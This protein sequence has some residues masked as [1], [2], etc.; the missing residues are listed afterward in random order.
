MLQYPRTKRVDVVDEYHGVSVSDPYRWL[1]DTESPETSAWIGAQNALTFEHLEGIAGR[2]EILSRLTELWGYTRYGTPTHPV[3]VLAG[4]RRFYLRSDGLQDQPVLWVEPEGGQARVLLDPNCLSEDGAVALTGFDVTH[5]GR[6][7]AYGVSRGGSDWQEVRVRDVESGHDRDDRVEWVKFSRPS[8]TRDGAGFFYSRY[9]EPDPGEALLETNRGQQL[10]YHRLGTS[11]DQD[12]L[13]YIRP[14]QPEWGFQADVTEEGRYV[15]IHVWHGSAAENRLFYLDLSDPAA[16]VLDGPVV[17]LLDDGDAAYTF[18][19][20]VD[21][22]IFVLTDRDA[23]RRKLV[24][25]DLDDPDPDSWTLVVPEADAVLES[26]RVL[27]GRLAMTY[28]EDARSALRVYTLEGERL[29]DIALPTLGSVAGLGGRETRSEMFFSF[30]SFLHPT[31]VYRH[32]LDSGETA[33]FGVPAQFEVAGMVTRQEFVTSKDGTRVPMFVTH[34]QDLKRD[35]ERPVMLYG[36][37]GFNVSLSPFFSVPNLV[38]LEMGGILAIPNLRGGGEYGEDWHR[39]GTKERKQNVFDDCIAAAEHLIAEGYTRPERIAISGGSNGGLLVSAC[40]T[41][42]PELFGV[43][44]PS[45]GVMDMLRFHRFTI[46]WAWVSDYGSADDPEAFDY[47][48]AYSPLHNLQNG[49]C[50]P[51][52]LVT[53]A[54]RDD[55][56]VPGHSFKFIARLQEAQGCGRPTLIRVD[57]QAGHGAGKPL[58]KLIDEARDRLVFAWHH[59]GQ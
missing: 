59:L 40:M 1:E 25:M 2:D 47:L 31:T 8:W 32:D 3:P 43:A 14:D 13:I 54:D 29:S 21:R 22:R 37:G 6:S 49:M 9:A 56:V 46:G 28:L 39:S 34:R 23:P 57:R 48:R 26:A 24:S 45:V 51:A 12:R 41:Q 30:T 50:Y 55:R 15:L 16:P 33:P 35:G 38:W 44:L 5:D 17:P 53:T 11:Q 20:N 27:G 42:R 36:Y 4:G 18:V 10:Y 7:V 19:A 52:T 58:R